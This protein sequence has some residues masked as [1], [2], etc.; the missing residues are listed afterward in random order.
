MQG[1]KIDSSV[2]ITF[3][4]A[5]HLSTM[6]KHSLLSRSKPALKNLYSIRSVVLMV[7]HLD[8]FLDLTVNVFVFFR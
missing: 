7:C 6:M 5:H 4:N 3:N 2:S 1:S 8:D